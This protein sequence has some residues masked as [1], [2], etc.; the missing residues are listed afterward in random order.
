[1]AALPLCTVAPR[2]DNGLARRGDGED[3]ESFAGTSV[4]WMQGQTTQTQ[5]REEEE[6]GWGREQRGGAGT[7]TKGEGGDA[8]LVCVR[9][10]LSYIISLRYIIISI[11]TIVT[12]SY[13]Y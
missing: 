13:C 1:M 9:S 2:P 7:E 12:I 3:G 5:T 8:V 6:G 10:T 11:L 4:T